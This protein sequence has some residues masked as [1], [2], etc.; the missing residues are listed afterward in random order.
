MHE[1]RKDSGDSRP[2]IVP[3]LKLYGKQR[4][5]V[6]FVEERSGFAGL[7][8][9]MGSGKT[10]ITLSYLARNAKVK[11]LRR[12]LIVC[13]LSVT[14]VWAREIKKIGA[15]WDVYVFASGNV[16]KS[17][18]RIRAL[19]EQ[20]DRVQV[21]IINFDAYWRYPPSIKKAKNERTGK[22]EA[23]RLPLRGV[24]KAILQWHPNMV[25][26]DEAQRIGD[27]RTM[28]S[29]F[30][31]ELRTKPYVRSGM[32]LTGTP[33]TKGI[34]N[35]FSIYKFI[36]PQMFG[37]NYGDFERRYIVKG[38]Y[39]GYQIKGYQRVAEVERKVRRTAFQMNRS[40]IFELPP[41]QTQIVPVYLDAKTRKVY[42]DMR[43]NSLAEVETVNPK[44]GKATTGRTLSTI[45]LTTL[46]R[47]QQ[48]V[49]GSLPMR[50]EDTDA[51]R[52]P[53]VTV[54]IGD[55]KLRA[56]VELT[57]SALDGDER[58]VI[59]TRFKRDIARLQ[60]AFPHHY[61]DVEGHCVYCKGKVGARLHL[62]PRKESYVGI[63][64]GDVP[65]A[66]REQNIAA[67]NSG[68]LKVLLVQIQT[69]SVGI[70]LTGASVAIF[71]SVSYNLGEFLQARD[72]IYRH[73]QKK[74]VIEYLLQAEDSIDE[75]IFAALM[76]KLDIARQ[77]T[78]L[79]YARGLLG[80]G[81]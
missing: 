3:R 81:K 28:Q 31:H 56:A 73:G 15:P 19:P 26:V 65:I 51:V 54:D 43:K 4:E 6:T 24:R 13:P 64:D 35:L 9:E 41:R 25:I 16:D 63:V 17:A 59:F 36:D 49:C 75:V 33:V 47:L 8:A 40:D 67:L 69:G 42:N 72:R 27:R 62:Q 76:G 46:I 50:L 32:A 10:P 53:L 1:L 71:Y 21:V 44:T 2:P 22:I 37:N 30:A 23:K 38:G 12:V 68:K 14:G 11:K 5:A 66:K 70:D 58:V 74:S 60:G 61:R 79:D 77:V 48:I 80:G 57:Q 29:K 34:E 45:M 18:S 78:S 39:G 7:F 52:E 55:E 20:L